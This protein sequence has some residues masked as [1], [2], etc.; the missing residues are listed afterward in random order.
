M[1]PFWNDV[2]APVLEAGGVR[3][4]VEI[5]ALRGEN[6]RQ[7]IEQLGPDTEL[8]VIDPAPGFD[9]GEHEREFAGQYVFHR[10]LSVDILGDL[11]AMDAALIDGDHNWYT[12][13]NECRLLAERARAEGAPLPILILHDVLWPYGRR[14]LYYNPETIPE[15]FRQPYAQKGVHLDQ[16][17]LAKG[18]SG[19]NPNHFNALHEGGPRN[20]VMTG[21]EDWMAEHPNPLRMVLLPIYFGLA[22]VVEEERLARQPELAAVL[23]AIEGVEGRNRL[24][25]LGER[26]RLQAM[27]FQHNA[28]FPWL[29]R[30]L[31]LVARYLGTVKA[32]LLNEHYLEDEAR[33]AHLT[34]RIVAG[35]APDARIL[36]DPVRQDPDHWPR[37]ARERQGPAGPDD[38]R[39]RSFVPYTDMGRARLDDLH[40]RLEVVK[41]EAVPGDL[42]DVGVGRGGAGI[43]LRAWL[44]AYDL[45]DRRVWLAD[46][47]RGA[48]EGLKSARW[49]ERGVAEFRADLNLVRDGFARFGLLD[50][51]VKFLPGQPAASLSDA[52]IEQIAVLR[53]G[54]ELGEAARRVLDAVYDRIP[55]GGF[56][57]VDAHESSATRASV[58]AFREARGLVAPCDRRD[59]GL[60]VWRKAAGDHAAP[61]VDVAPA[62]D[63]PR[64]PLAPPAPVDHVDLTVVVVFHNMAREARR[65]LHSLSRAYQTGVDDTSYEVIVIDNGSAP[66][67]ALSAE[68]VAEYGPEFRLLTLDAV[69]PSPVNALNAGIRAGR[70]RNFALMI[71]GAHVVTPGVLRWGLAGLSTYSPAVVATQQWYVGPGQQGDVMAQGYDQAYEDRLFEQIAWPANGYRLFEIG[72]FIGDRD[73]L[74]GLWESNCL[75]VERETLEQVGGFDESFDL[76]GAGYANLDLYE[77]LAAGPEITVATILGEGSFHQMHG[78]DTTNQVDAAERRTKVFDYS[79]QYAGLRGRAF[80]GPGKPVHYVGAIRSQPARRSRPRRLSSETFTAAAATGGPDGPP[81]TPLPLPEELGKAFTEAV[82]AT[83]PWASTS[84]L[85]RPV[86]TPPA[87]LVAYQEIVAA[88]RPDWIIETGSADGGR[89]LF[90]ASMC[91]LVGHGQVLSIDPNEADDR[92]RH[93]RLSHLT[94]RPHHQDVAD[95]VHRRVAGGRALVVLGSLVDRHTT[96]EEFERYSPLVPV[97]SYVI[98]TDTVVNGHP[99]W[100]GFGPGPAEAVKQILARNGNFAPDPTME[101]Y[102][103]S[104]NPGGYLRR[105][106]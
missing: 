46:E 38:G 103:L 41:A 9:P 18:A 23:D 82:Y 79:Q 56:V 29:A 30:E 88:V 50:G 24:L 87:D 27:V 89:S 78:G 62:T 70:G 94:G 105:V 99:V 51:R 43:F 90:L 67:Q 14:D 86:R 48:P 19:L 66:D 11:P 57:V 92:P 12:V 60:V 1:F 37:L 6:T 15:E 65:T 10:A 74:D 80:H 21:L 20:G 96:S 28:Y 63:L 31:R 45:K 36:R 69:H 47:F 76:P 68:A 3:R 98:I 83:M 77:R 104:F 72:H 13:Y 71:D 97:H 55:V 32:A 73:W 4:L 95:E 93:P 106:R 101:K 35:R 52:R 84:W 42:V 102:S 5:G 85:G 100:A 2:I 64:A 58:E 34:A 53:I 33:L 26:L 17:E 39:G 75:F 25:E 91:E 8:H 49:T 54:P 22:I 16:D 7:I 61:A 81:S 44:D 40:G 59:H